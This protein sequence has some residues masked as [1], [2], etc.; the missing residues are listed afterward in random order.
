MQF[1]P[2]DD[3]LHKH[4]V[5]QSN[6]ECPSREMGNMAKPIVKIVPQVNELVKYFVALFLN[7][8]GQ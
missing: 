3:P 1:V 4:D 2:N 5:R 7:F 8:P 6:T